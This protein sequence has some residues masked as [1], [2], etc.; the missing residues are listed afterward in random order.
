MTERESFHMMMSVIKVS[1]RKNVSTVVNRLHVRIVWHPRHSLTTC[2]DM[3]MRRRRMSN[4][5]STVCSFRVC[6]S[7]CFLFSSLVATMWKVTM[8]RNHRKMLCPVNRSFQSNY[9]DLPFLSVRRISKDFPPSPFSSLLVSSWG[10]NYDSWNIV[11]GVGWKK[12]PHNTNQSTQTPLDC[13]MFHGM[14]LAW[15]LSALY[16]S[17]FHPARPPYISRW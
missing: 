12:F 2:N 13:L 16:L 7:S 11:G 15:R 1:H 14:M 5:C 9:Y 6:H 17:S 4:I 8:A 3:C 10:C